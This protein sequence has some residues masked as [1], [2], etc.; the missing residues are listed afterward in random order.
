MKKK[1]IFRIS[2]SLALEEKL[3]ENNH[4][5][6][7]GHYGNESGVATHSAIRPE[8]LFSLAASATLITA[9]GK[10]CRGRW[11]VLLQALLEEEA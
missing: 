9:V 2:L 7:K 1:H 5:H 3:C 6:W 10:S 11:P 4:P 8:S